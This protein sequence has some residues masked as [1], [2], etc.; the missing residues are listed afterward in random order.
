MGGAAAFGP[1]EDSARQLARWVIRRAVRLG[2]PPPWF[3]WRHVEPVPLTRAATR[4]V[5]VQPAQRESH[6]LPR[7][8]ARRADLPDM[9]HWWGYAFRDVPD[10]QSGETALATVRDATVLSCRREDGQFYPAIVSR[11][12]RAIDMREIR[13]RNGHAEALRRAGAAG[14]RPARMDRAVWLL[15]RV[16][17]NHAHWLTAHVP[18]LL[19]L[20]RLGLLD[21]VLLPERLTRTQEASLTLLGMAP[22]RFAR[23]DE[24]RPLRVKELTLV[25]TD[26]FRPDLL[27]PVREALAPAL[28][29]SERTRRVYISRDR[30]RFRRLLNEADLL[31]LLAERGFERVFLEELDFPE[32]VDLMRRAE[33]VVAPHGAGLTNILFCAEGTPVVEI[34]SPEFPNP[35]FYAL[36]AAMGLAYQIVEAAEHGDVAPLERDLTIPPERLRRAL[37][38]LDGQAG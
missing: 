15:E 29:R 34:A 36:A 37:D 13:F 31:P 2:A 28:P 20:Q 32:Q 5:T 35:N 8:V 3:G 24:S 9:V 4:Y 26:R 30:A 6:P 38:R 27:R 17:D 14:R 22:E 18:K 25:Q 16:H 21:D 19:L 23:F 33:A 11:E 12:G 1:L 10:R 7:N